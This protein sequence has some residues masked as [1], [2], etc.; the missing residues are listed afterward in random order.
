MIS[1]NRSVKIMG[2]ILSVLSAFLL[3]G[4]FT[5]S[6]LAQRTMTRP[7][8]LFWWFTLALL[9]LPLMRSRTPGETT[10]LVRRHWRFFLAYNLIEAAGNILFF[11]LLRVI[12]PSIVSF[13]LS[14][15]PLFGAVIAFLYL[16][17]RISRREW[18]GGLISMSGVLV[19]TWASPDAG[20]IGIGLAVLM[21]LLYAF[22][23]V[24]VKRWVAEV[25]PR[26]VTFIRIICQAVFFFL[27][28]LFSGGFR[29]PSGKELIFLTLGTFSGPVFGMFVMFS[30]LRCLKATQVFLIRNLQP[31]FV[32][33]AAALFLRQYLS[34]RQIYGGVLILAGVSWMLYS[35]WRRSLKSKK[36]R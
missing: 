8:F 31:F 34:S 16:N 19:I 30:A 6:T 1:E 26:T 22:N 11:S 33:V 17:E 21:T 13:F 32:T 24:F 14:L 2:V 27:F 15:M 25:P 35:Q 23:N 9:G 10:K 36:K 7:L 20:F 28:I 12:H 29:F 18:A 4:V 3:T 5:F